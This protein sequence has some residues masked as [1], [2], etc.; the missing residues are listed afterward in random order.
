MPNRHKLSA[1]RQLRQLRRRLQDRETELALLRETAEAVSSEFDLRRLYHFVATRARELTQAETVLVPILNEDCTE[2]T[3]LAG[4]GEHADEIVGETLPLAFGVCG[5][6]F[7][8]RQP[9]WH[10]VLHQLSPEEQERWAPEAGTTILVPLVGKRHFLGGLSCINKRGGGTFNRRDLDLLTLFASQVSVA[11][12]NATVFEQLDG[13]RRRAEAFQAEL[14]QLNARLS[15]ANRELQ[16]LALHDRLT[17]LPNRNLIEDRL[18]QAIASAARRHGSLA[19]II[20]DLDNFKDVNDALGHPVGDRLLADVARRLQTHLRETDTV[21][22]LGGDEFAI[23]MPDADEAAAITAA[24]RIMQGLDAPFAFEETNFAVSASLGV[25]IYPQHGEDV[26]SL[27]KHADDAMYAAK[28]DHDGWRLYEPIDGGNSAD[29]LALLS[30]LRAAIHHQEIELAFQPKLDLATHR[31]T[32]VEALAR[33]HRPGHGPVAPDLFVPILEQTGLIRP[34]TLCVLNMA[35]AERH[36]WTARGH[37]LSMAVNL[38]AHNLRDPDLPEQIGQLLA[39]WRVDPSDLLLEVTESAMML[40][41]QHAL[42]ILG[43]LQAMGVQLA[44]D[45]FGTGYSSLGQ[46]KKLPV[47]E[48]KIDRT[49]V[50]DMQHD[51]DDAI[52]VRSVID[53][54]HNLGLRV[55]A[56][57]VEDAG[58]LQMLNRLG[59]DQVQGFHIAAPLAPGHLLQFLEQ[60]PCPEA[61]TATR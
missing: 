13:A 53:L 39:R 1:R 46:L 49:F 33:W 47:R 52:M 48:L 14:R 40:N 51:P 44:I 56:E 11:I 34:F 43:R 6:V 23:V 54:A 45:D 28:A 29:R 50:S 4:A 37:R 25:A 10:G 7:R 22:R 20:L 15:E 36:L 38:S 21:G 61:L 42:E 9:W 31:I 27:F 58:T 30:D 41:P 35:L 32:G 16:H 17:G 55:V 5:W 57:G 24:E 18:R 19:F 12:E 60:P 2:Y 3:Y 8:N 59:C 26:A